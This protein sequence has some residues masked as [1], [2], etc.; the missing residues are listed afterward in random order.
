MRDDDGAAA[1]E[2]ALEQPPKQRGRVDVQGG[3]GLVQQQQLRVRGE[4]PGHRHALR[5]AAGELPRAAR[6]EVG[7]VDLGQP[8]QGRSPGRRVGRARTAGPESDVFQRAQVRKEQRLLGQERRAAAVR[9][10]PEAWSAARSNRTLP[11]S[12]DL[13]VSGRSSPAMMAN[14][15]DLPAPLGPRTA[16]VSP[17]RG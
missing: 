9:G 10:G 11:S 4:G 17:A 3:H 12:S 6:G 8:V 1:G 14:S 13:P 16:T 15:V 5:L 7:G 2:H